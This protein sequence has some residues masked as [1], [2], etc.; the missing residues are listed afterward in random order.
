NELSKVRP[1]HYN[2]FTR[3]SERE[4]CYW[5]PSF[6]EKIH[7]PESEILERID[8][9]LKKAVR[10]RMISDVPLGAF[11]SGGVDSSLVV[12][13]MSEAAGKPCRTFS[14]GFEEL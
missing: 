2:V 4:V 7:L 6:K 13:M 3:D 8:E 5:R 1:G 9:G 14:I 11:L 10:R 12:A